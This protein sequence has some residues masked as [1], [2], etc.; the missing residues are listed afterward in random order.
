MHT[1][2]FIQNENTGETLWIPNAKTLYVLKGNH[3]TYRRD[4]KLQ[5]C[6][7]MRLIGFHINKYSASRTI[8][9]NENPGSRFGATS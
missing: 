9:K 2:R 5:K 6:A 8:E 4:I 3:T 1:N 7:R